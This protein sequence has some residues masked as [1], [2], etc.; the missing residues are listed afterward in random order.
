MPRKRS[1]PAAGEPAPEADATPGVAP[2]EGAE[3]AAARPAEPEAPAADA[4]PAES[5]EPGAKPAPAVEPLADPVAEPATPVDAGLAAEPAA[6]QEPEEHHEDE[7][8]PS[9]ASRAL[10]FLV[11][12]LG[13]AALGI[14]GAPKLAPLLP[15][16]LA[17][18]SAWLTPGESRAQA[19]VDALEAR[20]EQGLGGMESRIAEL[21]PPA[22]LDARI[23]QAV[24]ASEARLNEAMA[25]LQQRVDQADGADTRQRL[26]K[27]EAAIEGQ[28]A[29][30]AAIKE[31]FAGATAAGG[32]LTEETV[33]KIDVYRAELE[34]LR[35]EMGGLR[36]RV[37]A[38]GA[39]IDEVAAK[40]DRE[41][42]TAQ[43]K[44]NE[45]QAA[46]ATRLGAAE[47]DA[48]LAL[49]RAAL[50]SGQPFEEPLTRLGERVAVPAGL[51]AAAPTGV[52]T[53]AGLRDSFP[54]AAHAAI[55]ASIMASAGDG[56]LARSRAFLGA[57]VASR[58]LTPKPGVSPD[59]VLSRMEDKLRRDDL[60]G[61]LAEADQLPSEAA[62]A[63]GGWLDAARLR[64]GAV[65]GLA[66]LNGA[67]AATN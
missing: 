2:D 18:V 36:D 67:L 20:L 22:D 4:G 46:A 55:R 34:G 33:A 38:L 5:I 44:V 63:M 26:G 35:A 10:A 40:A 57:Q 65:D 25:A 15:S 24:G 28:V 50:A 13:G 8:G 39:R 27:L 29:E 53:L 51:S 43:S 54:D 52:A 6:T 66:E 41:I 30:L 42:T 16:G 59:A 45:I 7:P 58:S 62:T 23:E 37:G 9:F 47:T 14:W 11:I 3:D 49:V 21:A 31:Q 1:D 60:D 48:E 19:E 32:Q 64:A 61:A 12:L 56:L 17:P